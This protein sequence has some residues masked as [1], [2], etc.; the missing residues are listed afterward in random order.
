MTESTFTDDFTLEG[1]TCISEVIPEG[2]VFVMGD[3]R[4]F[5]KDSR[6]IGVVPDIDRNYW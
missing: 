3:N 6:H 2:H 1:N 4:R 5:S